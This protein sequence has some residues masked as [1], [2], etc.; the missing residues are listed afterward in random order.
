MKVGGNLQFHYRPGDP[1]AQVTP[2]VYVL[3][4]ESP[5]AVDLSSWAV[6]EHGGKAPVLAI[7]VVSRTSRKDYTL[8]PK[9]M[10]A[11]YQELGAREVVR[12]DPLWQQA[13]RGRR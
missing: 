6:W 1:T 10:L 13:R 5:E 11:R 12:Y 8:D 3:A 2:D 9:G 4:D 7:E